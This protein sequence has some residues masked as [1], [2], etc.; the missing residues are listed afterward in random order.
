MLTRTSALAAAVAL[1]TFVVGAMSVGTAGSAGVSPAAITE[2]TNISVVNQGTATRGST[3]SILCVVQLVSPPPGSPAVMTNSAELNF[4][5]KGMPTTKS[6]PLS[7][8]WTAVGNS[9]VSTGASSPTYGVTVCAHTLI[10]N[11]GAEST[12]WTCDFVPVPAPAPPN[13]GC[14]SPSG[15]GREPVLLSWALDSASLTSETATMVFTNTYP[16]PLR[17]SFTG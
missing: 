15:S 6:G 3:V 12:S 10:D 7:P 9:W 1:A 16:A 2:T 14:Q 4:D 13:V 17:P 8:Y 11:G 5:A